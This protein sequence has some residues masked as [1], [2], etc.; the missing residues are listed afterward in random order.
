MDKLMH[1]NILQY[2]EITITPNTCYLCLV[3]LRAKIASLTDDLHRMEQKKRKLEES[4]DGLV[5]EVAKLN[6]QG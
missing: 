4:Q 1:Y 5:E 6:A 2:I 3:Q